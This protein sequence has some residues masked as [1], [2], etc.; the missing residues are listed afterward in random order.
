MGLD[1]TQLAALTD[2]ELEAVVAEEM[3]K[4]PHERDDGPWHEMLRRAF[5]YM[6]KSGSL[7]RLGPNSHA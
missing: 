2:D 6:I 5:S 3:K 1:P 4:E 7:A